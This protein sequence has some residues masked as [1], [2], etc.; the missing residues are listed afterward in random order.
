MD[1]EE[2]VEEKPGFFASLFS[3]SKKKEV[4]KSSAPRAANKKVRKS[5]YDS[6]EDEMEYQNCM[7]EKNEDF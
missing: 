1:I 3:G 5:S 4:E 6:D 7:R 2:E